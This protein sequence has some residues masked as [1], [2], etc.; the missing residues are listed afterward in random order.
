LFAVQN[1]QGDPQRGFI[2]QP[3]VENAL[4]ETEAQLGHLGAQP[5]FK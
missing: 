5:V 1:L 3:S 2:V 4:P